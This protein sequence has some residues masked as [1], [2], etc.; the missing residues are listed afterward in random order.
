MITV[1][2]L[3]KNYTNFT[4]SISKLTLEEGNIYALLGEN[5]AGK[6]TFLE[7]LT[8]QINCGGIVL[9]DN[10]SID[11]NRIE[12]YSQL[13]YVR[14]SLYFYRNIKVVDFFK[15]VRSF[16]QRWDQLVYEKLLDNMEVKKYLNIKIKELSRGNI[17][18]ISL[19]ACL[20]C[21]NKYIFLDEPTSGLDISARMEV[22][23]ILKI[24]KSKDSIIIFSTH[25]AEDV[26][27]VASHILLLHNGKLILNG[28]IKHILAQFPS[29]NISE[30][31]MKNIN[32]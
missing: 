20:S 18:K 16:Y 12:I 28:E 27:S 6:T 19:I 10:L 13:G 31:F 17:V 25:L 15:F 1:Q 22:Y 3:V 23:K 7:S 32:S 26:E 29:M 21:M 4:L 11:N 9:F 8:G 2:Q 30:I 24:W 14:D 5:G